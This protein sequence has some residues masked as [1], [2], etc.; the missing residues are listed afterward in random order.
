MHEQSELDVLVAKIWIGMIF[1][2]VL[3]LFLFG[4]LYSELDE[5]VVFRKCEKKRL[6]FECHVEIELAC[7]L[8]SNFWLYKNSKYDFI[9][10]QQILS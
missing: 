2:K 10:L 8:T 9:L 7:V 1:L 3:F 6:N 5:T 4:N